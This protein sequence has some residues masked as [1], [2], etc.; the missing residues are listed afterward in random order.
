MGAPV[1]VSIDKEKI[2]ASNKPVA[3]IEL[4]EFQA[5]RRDP[6]VKELLREAREQGK[7]LEREG[8][9]RRLPA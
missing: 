3:E 5:A 1:A 4:D 9:I 7:K 6:Q 8:R 2:A